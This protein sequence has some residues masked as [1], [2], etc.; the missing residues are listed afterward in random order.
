MMATSPRR[1][2]DQ[3]CSGGGGNGLTASA[4]GY[5]APVSWLVRPAW[6]EDAGYLVTQGPERKDISLPVP[7]GHTPGDLPTARIRCRG[8]ADVSWAGG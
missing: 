7:A 1:D 5:A 4:T 3:S 8:R 2:V 6:R